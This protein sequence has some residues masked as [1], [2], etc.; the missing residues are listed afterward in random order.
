MSVL[1]LQYR[2]SAAAATCASSVGP[3][4]P[5][6]AAVASGIAGFHAAWYGQSGYMSL[7]PG[8][9]STATVAY[10]NTGSRGWV[11]GASGQ[12]AYL[13]TADPSPGQDQ[14]SILGGDGTNGSPATGW[15]RY[16][17]LA[18]QPAPYVGP[19]Q[20]AWFQF[21]V[22]APLAPGRYSIALR[23]V[24]EGAQW[25]EDYGVF[26][27]VVVLNPDGSQPPVTIGGLTF[28]PTTTARAD[29][30]PETTISSSDASSLISVVDGDV[31]SIEATFG[32]TFNRR[33]ILFAFGSNAT[34]T[35]GNLTIARMPPAD[36][37]FLATNEG[38]FYSPLTG[39]IFLN[40]FNDTPDG[41]L[42]TPRHELTHQLIAQIAGPNT[43]VPAWLNEGSAR[44]QEMTI[45]GEGWWAN[46]N[47]GTARSA[48]APV[49]NQLI[50][51][52][53][54][55]SQAFWNA[56]PSPLAYFEYYEASEAVRL[57][58]Q[59][60]G[61]AGEVLILDLMRQG[62]SFDAAF[63]AATGQTAGTFEAAFPSRLR[64]I[65]TY[66]AMLIATDT[67]VGAGL[68]YTAYGFAPSASLT[69]KIRLPDGAISPS[70]DAANTFG[71]YSKYLT[72]AGG[73]PVGS[74]TISVTDGTRT[75][76]ATG[77]LGG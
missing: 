65:G 58:R 50:P 28:N 24:I 26:W 67:P 36:A 61:V 37:T 11:A 73:W 72:V 45:P 8:T 70:T 30:Y 27:S 20:V 31:A 25:L 38:G 74:Y 49:V 16:N 46:L 44:L 18:I 6:P 41:R 33:P 12:T 47:A 1:P 71:T 75:A 48:A 7:C 23:P 77:S 21:R 35:G 56:R 5:P 54:L 59:D 57:L 68:S 29:V 17:R 9:E 4:I 64:A 62:V 42:R 69:I 39:D 60:V 15:P 14:P 43:A 19:G 22:R 10:Y 63:F 66:P 40:F 55:E 13:G 76:T 3:G 32:R 52:A 53:D 34:A 51:L 2:G